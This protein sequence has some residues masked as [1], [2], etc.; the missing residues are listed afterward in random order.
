MTNKHEQQQKF[1]FNV[2]N[3]R[4]YRITN[5]KYIHVW[6]CSKLMWSRCATEIHEV[7]NAHYA[8]RYILVNETSLNYYKEK[9]LQQ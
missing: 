7:Y 1:F 2:D 4:L 6:L 9:G 8:G 5:N 3:N